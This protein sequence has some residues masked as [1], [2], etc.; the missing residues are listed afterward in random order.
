M[1]TKK[2][3]TI[4][5]CIIKM[6]TVY[7]NLVMSSSFYIK[8]YE[9]YWSIFISNCFITTY[10]PQCHHLWEKI[11]VHWTMVV[12]WRCN[13]SHWNHTPVHPIVGHHYM[14]PARWPATEKKLVA[15]ALWTLAVVFVQQFWSCSSLFLVDLQRGR[16]DYQLLAR[17]GQD[18][19]GGGWCL[20]LGQQL[21]E[22]CYS[23]AGT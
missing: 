5:Y 8:F 13:R 7:S 16:F 18:R 22:L 1:Q 20:L 12:S 2:H 11:V 17:L 4:K 21:A 23:H 14:F 6:E 3:T 10:W 15:Q 19:W 9:L